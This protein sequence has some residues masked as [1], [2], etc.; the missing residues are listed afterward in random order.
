MNGLKRK[1]ESF[2]PWDRNVKYKP[3]PPSDQPKRKR[4]EDFERNVRPRLD[5][6]PINLHN[7]LGPPCYLKV[8]L[9]DG[10]S[11][12]LTFYSKTKLI[13]VYNFIATHR[14]DTTAF[15]PFWLVYPFPRRIITDQEMFTL[16]LHQAGL[17]PRA[18]LMIENRHKFIFTNRTMDCCS[19]IE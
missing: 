16:T 19:M 17:T 6:K 1:F 15:I 2:D 7:D 14:T 13:D 9:T 5:H 11:M 18:A 3:N 8:K 10:T 12:L 4:E